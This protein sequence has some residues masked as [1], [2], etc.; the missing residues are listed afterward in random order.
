MR[1]LVCL[2][3]VLLTL[4]CLSLQP[5]RAAA[6]S[7]TPDAIQDLGVTR[8]SATSVELTWP[9]PDNHA[10]IESSLTYDIRYSTT[11]VIR[12]ATWPLATQLSATLDPQLD[13]GIMSVV[14]SDLDPDQRYWFAIKASYGA[15]ESGISNSP[16]T[17]ITDLSQ[18]D[19]WMF[20]QS[21]YDS[22]DRDL[23]RVIQPDL[24]HRAAYEWIGT[25]F[26]DRN[27]DGVLQ[28]LDRLVKDGT[29][30]GSGISAKYFLPTIE[31]IGPGVDLNQADGGNVGWDPIINLVN[32]WNPH[33][34]AHLQ[35][36]A[37]KHIDFGF[38]DFEF[39]ELFVPQGLGTS[40]LETMINNV[41]DY[42]QTQYGRKV[43]I[44]ANADYGGMEY[45]FTNYTVDGTEA[46]DY[47]KNNYPI[48]KDTNGNYEGNFN[49]IP[50]L[51]DLA[52]RVNKPFYYFIDFASPTVYGGPALNQWENFTRIGNA[53]VLAA[54]SFPG[55]GRA[56]YNA[57]DVYELNVFTQQAN[58]FKFMRENRKLW[59]D[60]TWITPATLTTSVSNVWTSAFEQTGR[61]ILHLVNGNYNN[62]TQTMA[63]KENIT[64]TISLASEPTRVWLTTPD[65]LS[66]QRKQTLS[67]T[68]NNGIATIQVPKLEFH[69]V[70]VMDQG[71]SYDPVYNPMEIV[72]PYPNPDELAAG[73]TFHVTAVQTEG[74]RQDFD[75]YVNGVAGGNASVG[76]IDGEGNYKAPSTVPLSGPVT[77][78]AASKEDPA[79]S[80]EFKLEI[81]SARSLPWQ[82]TFA[83]DAIGK[84]PE[85]WAIVDGKG[86]WRI[87]QDA[88]D[89]VLH[90]FNLSDGAVQR[91]EAMYSP[92]IVSGNQS[93]TD[94]NYK[95]AVK[96]M[97][98]PLVWYGA[99]GLKEDSYIGSVFRFQD[100]K[101]YYEYRLC[102]DN[103]LRLFKTVNGTTTQLGSPVS[104]A[105]PS[106]GTYSTM[107]VKVF[108]SNFMA[109]VNGELI[110]YDSDS[111]IA[112]GGIGFTTDFTEN[113]FKD[114]GVAPFADDTA[115]IDEANDDSK[116]FGNSAN[117]GT[118]TSNAAYLGGDGSRFNKLGTAEEWISYEVE[119]RT[120]ARITTYHWN[121][122][123]INHLK[124]YT[125]DNGTAWTEYTPQINTVMSQ[126]QNDWHKVTYSVSE[127][128]SGT[129]Y[130]KIVWPSITGQ[131]YA[132]QVGRVVLSDRPFIDEAADGA[133]LYGHSS[134]VGIDTNN[135][136][137]MGG[138]GSRFNKL[139]TAEEWISY[140]TLTRLGARITTYHWN[141]AAINHLKVYTSDNGTAWTEY[142]PQI[143]TVMSQNQ[144]D[145]HKVTYSVPEFPSGTKYMKIVWPSI[146]GQLYAPQV[147]K[148]AL[149]AHAT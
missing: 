122:A 125:S 68:Y 103:K 89:K 3:A 106:V 110:R 109:F 11:N 33:G 114:I 69:D 63:S 35:Y 18:V 119:N 84:V 32:Y 44:S 91:G 2:L 53:Q 115:Y 25:E 130:M 148:V 45:S 48:T 5:P 128:P 67:F 66:N 79:V 16:A 120:D 118:D 60:L 36:K 129:K 30:I 14:L 143:N 58:L 22:R 75:W 71:D 26:Q 94:Y 76:T 133:K 6:D 97:K 19:V 15:N 20:N 140:E 64:V 54:G 70:I 86:D 147:G 82:E 144:Y 107:E 99:P 145:W 55:M 102:Y 90:N 112:A 52:D 50:R 96:T 121:G 123:A 37:K 113:Y 38:H 126:N 85:N 74:F 117:I 46:V 28:S 80:G 105:F 149:G 83:A 7:I 51:R 111:S 138:D 134:N 124:V 146:T 116:L 42:A 139:G 93:W 142:T 57:L 41:R 59:H 131:L 62:T 31:T 40:G 9:L 17:L 1:K 127:F 27:F 34:S 137:S 23:V 12:E 13:N 141:G 136:A 21:S 132:P 108:G 73:D 8:Q 24:I 81:V 135:A 100:R 61:T 101:N 104:A 4:G 49:H 29:S 87:S 78:K 10:A 39:D 95:F 72:F 47:Y 65:K 56:F 92:L 43:F 77:I 88:G 98:T